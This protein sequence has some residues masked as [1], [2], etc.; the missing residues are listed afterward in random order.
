MLIKSK[1]FDLIKL[2]NVENACMHYSKA[3]SVKKSFFNTPVSKVIETDL[4]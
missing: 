4:N 2:S 1:L 3:S